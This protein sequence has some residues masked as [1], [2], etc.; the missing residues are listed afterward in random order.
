MAR[1]GRPAAGQRR[2]RRRAGAVAVPDRYRRALN[3]PP[4]LVPKGGR[5]RSAT[6]EQLSDAGYGVREGRNDLPPLQWPT[7]IV[8]LV[9]LIGHQRL[10]RFH[11]GSRRVRDPSG[12]RP[13]M[14]S[15]VAGRALMRSN[16]PGRLVRVTVIRHCR[17]LSHAP[18]Q[19]SAGLGPQVMRLL[20]VG[21]RGVAQRQHSQARIEV[22]PGADVHAVH[23]APSCGGGIGQYR[24]EPGLRQFEDLREVAAD[25]PIVALGSKNIVP[26]LPTTWAERSGAGWCRLC[27]SSHGRVWALVFRLRG[28]DRKSAAKTSWGGSADHRLQ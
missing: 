10:L 16:L 1:P 4:S 19:L 2:K 5:L 12:R 8:L 11:Q 6:Q 15:A 22:R 28:R 26:S 3:G 27:P 25:P 24:G 21:D 9:L 17:Y 14:R 7:R 18:G 23:R 20:G 13:P